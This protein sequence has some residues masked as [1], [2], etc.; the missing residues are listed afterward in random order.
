MK[1][2]IDGHEELEHSDEED[3]VNVTKPRTYGSLMIEKLT[4]DIDGRID[5]MLQV[6]YCLIMLH[7]RQFWGLS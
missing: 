3:D 7:L 5:F 2:F 1:L 6:W 4:G